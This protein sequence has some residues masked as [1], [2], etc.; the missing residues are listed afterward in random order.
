MYFI[1]EVLGLI[2]LILSPIIIFFRVLLGKEDPKRFVEKYCIYQQKPKYK[3]VIWVHGASV[4]EILSVVPLIKKLEKNKKI[5]KILITSST[6]SSAIVFDKYKFKKTIH[7]YFPIDTNY[8]SQKFIKYWSPKMA[9]FVESEIWP[10]MFKNLN[11]NEIPIILLN[12]RITKKSFYNWKKFPNFSKNLFN[13]ISL[14]MP[15]NFETLKYLKNLGV[16]NIKISGNLKFIGE[17]KYKKIN[18]KFKNKF[19]NRDTWC[20]A[21]IHPKEELFVGK[22]H[23][24][25]KLINRNLL[26]I[27]IPRHINKSENII[28]NLK[29]I[30]LKTV[31]HSSSNKINKDTDIYL[32]DTYGETKNFYKLS[33]ITF[34]GGSL[35]PHGG[36]NPLEPARLGNYIIHGKNVENFKE[37]YDTLK[38]LNI[39]SKVDSVN[40][41]QKIITKKIYYKQ[42]KFIKQKLYLIGKK[43]LIKNFF[44]INKY[45]K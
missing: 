1:Y 30:G 12:A 43:I 2:L 41:M 22:V 5:K 6:T 37:V 36:Q 26:T 29:K 21:S 33:K 25:M 9:I 42:S 24:K 7:K 18:L 19:K 10:N 39:S 8:L 14:A 20:A 4:G 3:K 34:L 16:K 27:I 44:E 35:I 17:K 28:N 13:K 15:Q 31:T 40:K 38:N 11:L 32:V 23:K 45:I